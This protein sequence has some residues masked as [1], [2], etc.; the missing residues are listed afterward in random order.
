MKKATLK[1]ENTLLFCRIQ[2]LDFKKGSLD[3]TFYFQ[4]I[5]AR[6]GVGERGQEG[7]ESGG[8]VVLIYTISSP[9]WHQYQPQ[10]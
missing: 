10:L 9:I 2:F 6:P 8:V 5:Q 7:G 4:N 1:T 3:G